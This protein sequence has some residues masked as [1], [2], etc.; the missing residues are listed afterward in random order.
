MLTWKDRR[1]T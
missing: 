1:C